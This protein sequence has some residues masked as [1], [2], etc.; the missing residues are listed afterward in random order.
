[1]SV[2]L[3]GEVSAMK[4]FHVYNDDC[5]VGLEK[6]GLLN[7]DTGFKLQHGTR[8]P[9]ERKFNDYAAVGS[10]F[11]NM[12]K[13]GN[14]PFYVDRICGGTV[15]H[16]YDWD[17]ALLNTYR[18]MLG[19]WFLGVQLHESGSNL[20]NAEWPALLRVT[21]GCKGPYDVEEL[22]EKLFNKTRTL[23]D[24]TALYHR[25]QDSVEYYANKT[26]PETYQEVLGDIKELFTRR[27]DDTDGH[28]LPVDSYYMA[29]KLQLEMGMTTFM[30]EVGSQI[31]LMRLQ[32]A[33][34]RGI[35]ENAGKLWGTYYE[36]WRELPHL[37]YVMPCF[38]DHP[39]NEWYLLQSM[40]GDD[41]SSYGPNGGSSRLLQ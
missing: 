8:V 31:P 13:D 11:Y 30:P 3:F 4:F 14:I 35:A 15:Y 24:G 20:V 16:K 32:V 38:N 37:G 9:F 40:H 26:Y 17:K 28:I 12:I 25:S 36:C 39:M 5:Y 33:L 29:T 6:N 1:M 21:N 18:E 2:F 10:K 7:K 19:D 41:F 27:M 23:P 22:K 34:A